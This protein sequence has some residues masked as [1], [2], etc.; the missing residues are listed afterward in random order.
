M[1]VVVEAADY[2]AAVALYRDVLDLRPQAAF[3]G[4]GGARVV[5]LDAGRATLEIANPAQREMID[6][7]EVGRPVSPH[8][9]LAFQVDRA[10]AATDALVA[11]GAALVAP[12]T[13]T[14]WNS[15]NSRLETPGDLQIT[16]FQELAERPADPEPA[17]GRLPFALVDVFGDGPLTGNPLAVV[18]LTG[19]PGTVPEAW[20]AAVAREL[21]QSETTFVL[22]G[23]D[24]ATRELRSFTAGG[25]EVFGAGHNA[26][27]A[28][29]W[30][31][32][33]G[34]VARP[35]PGGAVVQLIGTERLPVA[36]GADGLL[37]LR[38][39]AARFG[40]YADPELVARA[41]GLG[42]DDVSDLF[43]PQVADTGAAHLMVPLRAR[44][45]LA[46]AT[47]DRAALIALAEALDFEGVYLAWLDP[48]AT[49]ARAHTRFF[50]PR[51]GLDEDPATGTAA[52]PL[53]ALL[54]R[55]GRLGPDR[56]LTIVQGEAMGRP[57]TIRATLDGDGVVSVAGGGHVTLT[58]ALH[59]P[60]A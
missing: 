18:D 4:E 42:R 25:V 22:P 50:N 54:H 60:A 47:P 6:R 28:W 35:G 23:R 34:R 33:T 5:I 45:A 29:W 43:A 21:N 26:L 55:D 52:G 39:T 38:Q 57:S 37:E 19:W 32:E 7:V 24:G 9:R 13:R 14:P 56:T 17:G 8:I 15:L 30:L 51:M 2:E 16:L 36:V 3:Q 48:N 12:P 20:Y 59:P 49:G 58:G 44:D 31:F 53:A 10:E 1:R 11:G 46:A 40:A 27:G 41:V